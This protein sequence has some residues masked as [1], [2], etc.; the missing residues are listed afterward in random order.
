MPFWNLTNSESVAF[1]NGLVKLLKSFVVV[2]DVGLMVLLM[3]K[4]HNFGVDDGL[5]SAIIIREVGQGEG[6]QAAEMSRP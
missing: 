6:L 4:L 5:K 3:M 2:G 1:V